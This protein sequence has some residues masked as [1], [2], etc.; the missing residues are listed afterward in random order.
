MFK[1]TLF[2]LLGIIAMSASQIMAG[3][4]LLKNGDFSGGTANWNLGQ[5]GGNSSGSVSGGEYRIMVNSTG[6]EHWHVQ[7]TQSSLTLTQG[8][9][10]VFS[11]DAYKGSHNSG[12]Q[13][14]Q[15]NVGQSY[16]PYS[17]HLGIADNMVT[18]T[19]SKIR[20]TFSFTMN[21]PTDNNARVEFNCGKSQ[22][23]FYIDNVS[24]QEE[25][26][27][28]PLLTAMPLSIDFGTIPM[29]STISANVTLGN[30][31][32]LATTVNGVSSSS[33]DV[34]CGLTVPVIVPA[35]GSVVMPLTYSPSGSGHFSAT[36][37]IYS[38]ASDNPVI[39]VSITADPV[40]AGIEY[41]PKTLSFSTTPEKPVNQ[42]ITL[43]NSSNKPI[44]WSVVCDCGWMTAEPVSGTIAARSAVSCKV[45]AVHA[46]PG[47]YTG[48]I[49]LNHSA[50]NRP[51]PITVPVNL[52]V[53]KGY[54]PSSPYI[55]NPEISIDFIRDIAA[56]RIKQRDNVNGG[57]FTNIDRQ[58]NS[59]GADEKALCGQSRIAYAFVRA[60]MVTGEESYLEMAHHA[61]KFLYDHG[62]N[63]GWYFVTDLKGN[64]VSHWG[65]NDWWSFQQHYALVGISAMVEASGGE[66]VWGDGSESDHTWLMR[67][68]TSN[69]NRLWDSN[70]ATKGY[71]NKANTSWTNR[72]EKGFTP[73]VDGVTTHALLMA[74]MYDSLNHRTRLT[75]LAD[76]IVDHFIPAMSV[77]KAGF[78][79]IYNSDWSIDYSQAN[80]DIG[81]GYKTAWVLQRAYLLNK[82]RP[83]Y[84]DGAQAIMLDL[85]E[86]G[87]YDT[88]Y[89][90]PYSN[91]NWQS[92][93]IT[94]TN[95]DFWMT[96]QGL[97]SG[98]ISY[99]TA[100]TQE[101]RDMYMR[102]ADGSIDFFMNH[103]MDP[104]Y[105][106]AYNVVSRD[107]STVVDP[108]KG[109]LFTAG[110]H[111]VELGYYAY[112]YGSLYYHK[113]PVELYYYYPEE[114]TDRS[115]VLTPIA[116]EDDL[117]K[118]VKVTLNGTDY[119]DFDG[120]TR[121]V[122][123]AAGKGGKLKVTFGFKTVKKWTITASANKGGSINPSGSIT[124]TEGGS[125]SFKITPDTGYEI[126]DVLLNGISVGKISSYTFGNVLRNHSLEAF[127]SPI[128][129]YSIDASAADG[130]T[131][132]PSGV[133]IVAESDSQSFSIVP[134]TGY[135]IADVLVDGI[136]KG[137]LS[138]YTF[139][140]VTS[141]HV[142]RALFSEA[143][144]CTISATA[145]AGGA[146]SPSGI[147]TVAEG[148]S[149]TFFFPPET[150]YEVSSVVVDGTDMGKMTSYTFN[151]VVGNHTIS[152]SFALK[153]YTLTAIAGSGGTITPSGTMTVLHGS[154]QRFVIAANPG[155]KISSVIVDGYP[156]GTISAYTFSSIA[157][158]HSISVSFASLSPTVVYRINCGGSAL[159]PFT[160]DN[161]YSGG[162]ART[163]SNS[164]D[165]SKTSNSAPQQV[166]K[167][168]RYGNITYTLP[169]LTP[170]AEYIVR[171]H[172]AELYW[173]SNGKR[174]FDVKINGTTVL[175]DYD[176]YAESGAQYRAITREF[177]ATATG[178][179]QIVIN[180][181]TIVDNATIEGI[182][183]IEAV[184]ND[185]PIIVTPAAATPNPVSGTT[186]AL[187][188]LGA[189]DNGEAD[190]VY[191]WAVKGTA[192]APVV[193]SINKTN[194]SKN[195]TATFSKAGTYTL[196]VTVSDAANKTVSS[197]VTVE[198]KQTLTDIV[199]SPANATIN[200][201]ATQLFKATARDQFSGALSAQPL[202]TWSVSGGGA[203]NPDGLFT[204]AATAGGPYTVT[205]T[206]DGF[207]AT[208]SVMV[209]SL[210]ET[211]Y[212]INCGGS[213]SSPFTQDKYYSGGTARTVSNSIDTTKAANSAPKQVYKSERYGNMTYTLPDLTPAAEYKVRL[214]F[215]ELYWTSNGKRRFSVKINGSTVLSD[216]DIYAASG[217]QYRAITRE[218]TATANGSGQIVIN[219]NTIVDNATIEGIEILRK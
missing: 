56:F 203:I 41:D 71:F 209:T 13:T 127:F 54:E 201:L 194:S 16:S 112:L 110:Y 197:P 146:I 190:L 202:F 199:V 11:F 32:T 115:F 183:I 68:I 192:P 20:H 49:T 119:T 62:W 175:P 134:S 111:S 2:L 131:I 34:T 22:G 155:Y 47:S 159:S 83:E 99:Y 3:T 74:L 30:S 219:F 88:V 98:L 57:Y 140:N 25:S 85:W 94:G 164:I 100:G 207:T 106:E 176:I 163:V 65:H 17:S 45:T 187:S 104:L 178:S 141:D 76:N 212:R 177:S 38:N 213:A 135:R 130:G 18:L 210:P 137:A 147:V 26:A 217:A 77:A 51:S 64:Y 96:E 86:N 211:V 138:G 184:P 53:S 37:T 196:E 23:S 58:G 61:L 48:N 165:T 205:A 9:K 156:V 97:T 15:I 191:S 170:A 40:P 114:S 72:W 214:H 132:V 28:T 6:S 169:D 204:A 188:V 215:A 70:E 160:Q 181:N 24:L 162:T 75:E 151:N 44:D 80:M 5:Y 52:L 19:T 125:Q 1:N 81:H 152:V 143:P 157:R 148:A 109:G 136:S 128:P 123:L 66:L 179:G 158:S 154:S 218:F 193:F 69:Y 195:T 7:F 42:S 200:V 206:A 153:T 35:K 142:I 87:A 185:P 174:R 116:I 21:N 14:M 101:Q 171:L 102:V 39:T 113:K 43:S 84:L 92:G 133:V 82:D 108:N 46:V 10:Y 60:F 117:L 12:T 103:L 208:A 180:F 129:T 90:A 124:V 59:T 145:S 31:G 166:Y 27:D 8:K 122:R 149:K 168:E 33:G 50:S 93:A 182:E 189:D 126:A 91:L 107:G 95:K 139:I 78:P 186:T 89:G 105:G 150:G 172:F 198:V 79:E 63:N 120:D 4:E 173:T 55:I 118:I 73:T 167:S 29:D 216:Y 121:T 67:G 161:Y 144:P 36:V